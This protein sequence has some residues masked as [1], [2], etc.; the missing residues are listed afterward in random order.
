[1][2]KEHYLTK[3]VLDAISVFIIILTIVI[4]ISDSAVYL[5]GLLCPF[6]L[7]YLT[8]PFPL[9]AIRRLWGNRDH[10]A[11]VEEM[12]VEHASMKGVRSH[13]VLDL[14]LDQDVRWQFLTI[15]VTF[16]TLQFSGINAVS[17]MKLVHEDIVF[18]CV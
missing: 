9:V 16:T 18:G 12:L 1:M 15:L 11:E 13:T 14:I 5:I 10:S 17:C 6:P 2:P 4:I 3:N 7:V 8:G